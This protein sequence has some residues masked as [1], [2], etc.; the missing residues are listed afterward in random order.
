MRDLYMKRILGVVA[1]LV[2]AASTALAPAGMAAAQ[3]SAALSITP[4]KDYTVEAGK[5]VRDKLTIRNTDSERTLSLNLRVIDFTF[6]DDGGTPNLMLAED[7][8]QTAWSLKPFIKLAQTSL[9]VPPKETRSVEYTITVPKG[10]GAGSYYSAISYA[11]GTPEGGNVGLSATGVTL[12]FATVP[13]ITKQD[14]KLEKFG[15]Y[16]IGDQSKKP[17]F[18][19]LAI[20]EP[21]NIAYQLKNSGNIAESPVGTVVLKHMFGQEIR[22]ND[23]NVHKSLALR[24]QTRTFISCITTK[25]QSLED[26]GIERSNAKVC[27]NPPLWP[28]LYTAS[29]DAFYGQNGN[30]TKELSGKS[31]FIYAPLW[32]IITLAVVL[33]AVAFGIW[34]ITRKVKSGRRGGMRAKKSNLRR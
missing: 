27:D 14:L 4:R 23:I 2:I 10:Q 22:I 5:S 17:K 33:A 16:R 8:P 31:W 11:S 28:G 12:A 15:A 19:R 6:M 26:K 1:A 9:T 32:F 30:N 7:A 25:D 20:N 13:G 24:G 18:L 3:S 34:Q 29:L 21:Q